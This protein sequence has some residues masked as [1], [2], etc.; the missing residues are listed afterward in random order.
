MV[1]VASQSQLLEVVLAFGACGLRSHLLHG[2]N[3]QSNQNGNDGN[4][5]QQFNQGKSGP[6]PGLHKI[7]FQVSRRFHGHDETAADFSSLDYGI[8][9]EGHGP[10]QGINPR[11]DTRSRNEPAIRFALERFNTPMAA[12]TAGGSVELE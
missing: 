1:I 12:S 3:Q 2:W 8:V 11:L 6:R 10:C 4:D 9:R 5:D 7:L